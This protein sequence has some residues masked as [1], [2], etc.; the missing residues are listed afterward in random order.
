M[1]MANRKSWLRAGAF[2]LVE[3]LVVISIIAMLMSILLP[4]LGRSRE[5]ARET[6]C[7]AN[8]HSIGQA[9]HLYVEN[10]SGRSMPGDYSI[11]WVVWAVPTDYRGDPNA[12]SRQPVNLGHLLGAK[13]LPVPEDSSS[14]IFCPSS[15][16]FDGGKPSEGFVGG[17]G[18]PSVEAYATYMM[19][20]S[21]D[22]FKDHI[23][24]GHIP[25]SSHPDIINFLRGDGSVE[26]FRDRPL[27]YEAGEGG[28]KIAEVCSRTGQNFPSQ[29]LHKWF[30]R[31]GIDLDEA[32]DYLA[33]PDKWYQANACGEEANGQLFANISSNESV[34]S[35]LVCTIASASGPGTPVP[36]PT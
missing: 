7:M 27:V 35:D 4:S 28:E 10:N 14:V 26:A 29:L 12:L 36:P 18:S 17:W 19:N 1:K 2:T 33:D 34:V 24:S 31:G 20:I 8:L 21:L 22:N 11:P 9:M 5:K 25:V 6:V 13:L 3:I 32:K 30:S 15:R 23:K 16:S